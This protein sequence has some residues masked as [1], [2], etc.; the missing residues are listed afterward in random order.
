MLIIVFNHSP[1]ICLQIGR[2]LQNAHAYVNCAILMKVD[3]NRNFSV[4]DKPSIVFGGISPDFVGSK[5]SLF[6]KSK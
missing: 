6:K 5:I 1:L 2:R 3:T 4:R